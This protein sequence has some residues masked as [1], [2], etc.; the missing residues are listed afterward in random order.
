MSLKK[1]ILVVLGLFLIISLV[2]LPGVQAQSGSSNTGVLKAFSV[3]FGEQGLIGLLKQPWGQFG[4]MIIAFY[5]VLVAAFSAGLRRVEMFEGE[6]GLGLNTSGLLAANGFTALCCLALFGT[7][8]PTK[9]ARN[10]VSTIGIYG[11][12]LIAV[13]LSYLAYGILEDF[14]FGWVHRIVLTGLVFCLVIVGFVGL[15]G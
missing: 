8:D 7:G 3:V 15:V 9:A 10:V 1:P 5:L 12:V 13:I 2:I 6:G 14:D 11:I 4:I